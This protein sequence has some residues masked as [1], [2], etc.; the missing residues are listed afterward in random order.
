[1][2]AL[3]VIFT[4][5]VVVACLTIFNGLSQP[6]NEEWETRDQSYAAGSVQ[7]GGRELR[8]NLFGGGKV[9]TSDNPTVASINFESGRLT[10]DDTQANIDNGDIVPL[11]EDAE[12]VRICF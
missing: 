12:V 6:E 11:P 10:L 2:R 7:V 9:A 3:F 1:M 5:L 8:Y 4:F